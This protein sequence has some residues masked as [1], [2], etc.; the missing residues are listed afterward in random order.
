M[1]GVDTI[2]DSIQ[3]YVQTEDLTG[4]NQYDAEDL[5]KQDAKKFIRFKKL[6]PVLQIQINRFDYNAELEQMVKINS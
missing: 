1:S 6:P 2:E 3:R 5:G 4:D